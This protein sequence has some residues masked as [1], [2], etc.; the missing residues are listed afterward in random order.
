MHGYR[1]VQVTAVAP[2]RLRLAAERATGHIFFAEHDAAGPVLR[3]EMRLL[4]GAL[5][6]D[7]RRRRQPP[8]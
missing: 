1:V 4:V 2:A 3:A 7:G 8:A 6:G 5:G